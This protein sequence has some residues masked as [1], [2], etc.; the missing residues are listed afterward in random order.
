MKTLQYITVLFSALLLSTCNLYTQTKTKTYN[1]KT[2]VFD[3]SQKKVYRYTKHVFSQRPTSEH[4]HAEQ[5]T[6]FN[7]IYKK[8][9]SVK[10]IKELAGKHSI[11]TICCNPHGVVLSVDFLFRDEIFYSVQEIEQLES[12]MLK[13]KF[14]MNFDSDE[15]A[16]ENR[17]YYFAM[18]YKF[19]LM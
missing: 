8:V 11:V 10:R 4:F 3:Y 7:D 13:Y 18:V 2:Y 17:N 6:P 5:T 19:P 9:L 15:V 14:K 1:H 16:K 12:A